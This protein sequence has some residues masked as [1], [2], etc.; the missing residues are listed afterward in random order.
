MK[1]DKQNIEIGFGLN[2]VDNLTPSAFCYD[3]I[4]KSNSY[5][6]VEIKL[7]EYYKNKDLK[8]P[9]ISQERECDLVANRIAELLDEYSFSFSLA[10]LQGIHKRLFNEV[11]DFWSVK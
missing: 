7:K 4:E 6:E 1:Y 5:E 8:N 10:T 11:F 3:V 9:Q 2:Q